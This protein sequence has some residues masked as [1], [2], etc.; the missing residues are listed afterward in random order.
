MKL[1]D[2]LSGYRLASGLA[3]LHFGYFFA[4][5]MLPKEQSCSGT[6]GKIQLSIINL[7]VCHMVIVGM[8]LLSLLL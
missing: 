6:M 4:I 8:S 7:L 3:S 2:P 5:I 1:K